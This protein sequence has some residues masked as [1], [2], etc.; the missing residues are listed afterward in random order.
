MYPSAPLRIR[1]DPIQLKQVFINLIMNAMDAVAEQPAGR[2]HVRVR[3][4]QSAAKRIELRVTD[5]GHGIATQHLA[6]LFESFYSTKPSGMGLGL[7]I[8]RSIVEAHGGQIRAKKNAHG[9]ATFA[10]VLPAAAVDPVHGAVAPEAI[11][12][13][14]VVEG[15]A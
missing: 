14:G 4:V 7:S 2:R 12:D 15:G 1:G 11:H 8:A 10:V 9:G 3:V 13:A 5:T 6:L